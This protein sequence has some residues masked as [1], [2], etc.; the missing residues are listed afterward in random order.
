MSVRVRFRCEH[1]EAQPDG[2]TQRTLEGQL[3]DRTR[4]EFR[5]AQPGG[6]LIWMA[7]GALGSKLYACPR[8]HDELTAHVRRQYGAIR[9]IACQAEPFP[10]LWPDGVSG[11]DERGLEAL[12]AGER[13][14]ASDRGP[15]RKVR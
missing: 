8:H 5:D 9:S 3:R 13:S 10:A 15:A 12:L 11:F 4:G 1:C 7:G 2:V 6:W 14:A